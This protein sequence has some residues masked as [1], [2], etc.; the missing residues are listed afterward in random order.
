M[1]FNPV[2]ERELRTTISGETRAVLREVFTE[3]GMEAVTYYLNVNYGVTM[4]DA[5]KNPSRFQEALVLFLGDFGGKILMRRITQ[6]ILAIGRSSRPLSGE[7]PDLS[8][9]VAKYLVSESAKRES[10]ELTR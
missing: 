3:S 6:R 10:I 8:D 4:D 2:N 1:T 5:W 7:V 9:C